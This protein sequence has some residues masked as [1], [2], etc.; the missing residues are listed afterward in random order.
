M[1]SDLRNFVFIKINPGME[2]NN[3]IRT[4]NATVPKCINQSFESSISDI[5]FLMPLKH[6]ESKSAV[7]IRFSSLLY[8]PEIYSEFF[9]LRAEYR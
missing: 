4:F 3:I 5:A 8:K 2:Y 7:E 6:A 9:V 1:D